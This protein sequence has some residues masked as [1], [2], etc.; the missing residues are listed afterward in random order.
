MKAMNQPAKQT[1]KE[2]VKA[3]YPEAY[4]HNWARH[5]S[6]VI[7]TNDGTGIALNV[8][9]RSEEAA[10]RSAAEGLKE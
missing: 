8:C 6:W 2:R 1:D 9:D 7:Y 3:V 10:W 5:N 4:A